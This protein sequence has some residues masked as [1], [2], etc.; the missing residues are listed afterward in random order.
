MFEDEEEL[1]IPLD[2]ETLGRL[3][4]F[5]RACGKHPARAAAELLRDLLIEDD[6]AHG[7]L[8]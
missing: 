8:N 7:P 1:P 4:R 2:G 6:A 5:A 3:A